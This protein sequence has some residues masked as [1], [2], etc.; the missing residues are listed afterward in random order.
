MVN[1]VDLE[2]VF[3]ATQDC[4]QLRNQI[5]RLLTN[6]DYWAKNYNQSELKATSDFLDKKQKLFADNGCENKVLGIQLQDTK[7]VA[8]IYGLQD[9]ARIEAQNTKDVN[10]RKL[11]G[12]T[13]LLS[14]LVIVIMLKG[15]KD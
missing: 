9:K 3:P 1:S 2:L 6:K 7:N 5:D 10:N 14:S 12:I 15:E 4:I 13:V 11:I 8:D